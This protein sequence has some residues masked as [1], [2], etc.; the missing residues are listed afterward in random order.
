MRI[1]PCLALAAVFAGA[2]AAAELKPN[3]SAK[4]I[5]TR[6]RVLSSDEFEGRAPGTPGED[7]TVA[8]L[9]S[10]FRKIG[11]KPGNPNGTYIQNV[12]LIGITSDMDLNFV[13]GGKEISFQPVT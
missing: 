10:E 12:P 5:E 13:A 4:S 7:K 6:V 3:I 2:A 11:V 1:I 8:Y 9:E